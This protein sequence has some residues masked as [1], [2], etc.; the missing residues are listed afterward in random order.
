MKYAG[1]MA[2]CKMAPGSICHPPMIML[3]AFRGR[4]SLPGKQTS[5]VIGISHG[6]RAAFQDLI[7]VC[8]TWWPGEPH[9]R[10]ARAQIPLKQSVCDL[11]RF[12]TR[13]TTGAQPGTTRWQIALHMNRVAEMVQLWCHDIRRTLHCATLHLQA[14]Q[15]SDCICLG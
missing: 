15:V 9:E 7:G 11:E 5:K 8:V 10:F 3:S 12:S 13:C 14:S 2:C 4:L 6:R 1:R